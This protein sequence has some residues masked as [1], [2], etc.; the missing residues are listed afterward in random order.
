MN[1]DLWGGQEQGTFITTPAVFVI[2]SQ[3]PE[4]LGFNPD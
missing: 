1:S 2:P 3:L 4:P